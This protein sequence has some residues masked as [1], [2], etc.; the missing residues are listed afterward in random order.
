MFTKYISLRNAFTVLLFVA[1]TSWMTPTARAQTQQ[2]R[3]LGEVQFSGATKADRDSGV[4]V[5]GKYLGYVKEL[6]GDKQ[7]ELLP[8]DH[9]ISV[10][11]AGFMDFTKEITVEPGQV[12]EIRVAM[13][14]NPAAVYPGSDAAELKLNVLP[15]RAAVF[16]DDLY[17]GHVHDF[18]GAVHTMLIS[19]GV[20]RISIELPGYKTFETEI[21]PEPNQKTEIKTDLVPGSIEQAGALVR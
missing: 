19:P 5:D 12:Q 20:H 2:N 11:Q 18:G 16:V 17:V 3:I 8:G 13:I 21:S 9:Q 4:W 10:R 7:I 1:L 14:P 15:D 6:K